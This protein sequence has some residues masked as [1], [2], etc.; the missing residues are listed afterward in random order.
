[1]AGPDSRG[2]RQRLVDHLQDR[3]GPGLRIADAATLDFLRQMHRRLH[4]ALEGAGSWPGGSEGP[5]DEDNLT[6]WDDLTRLRIHL[7][8]R[9][10]IEPATNLETLDELYDLHDDVHDKAYRHRRPDEYHASTDHD[11]SD[12]T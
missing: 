11:R 2:E 10:E 6:S 1:M 8:R 7:S 5:H 9:H 12:F 3:H 4:S